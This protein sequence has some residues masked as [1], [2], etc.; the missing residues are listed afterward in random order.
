MASVIS[1][2]LFP[3]PYYLKKLLPKEAILYLLFLT[4]ER[5][6]RQTAGI[7]QFADDEVLIAIAYIL[8][9]LCFRTSESEET[10]LAL[11]VFPCR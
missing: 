5:H 3:I 4:T 8:Y 7:M 2:S 9:L 6:N 10:A 11:D 1:Y